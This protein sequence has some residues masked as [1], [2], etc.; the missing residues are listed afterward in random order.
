MALDNIPFDGSNSTGS[1]YHGVILRQGLT[2]LE[3][4]FNS[5]NNV[6]NSMNHM[7]DGDGSDIAHFDEMV[8][9][10]GF[11]DTTTAK[12]AWDELNSVLAKLNTDASVTTVNSSL[13]Q[14]FSKMR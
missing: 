9:R 12:A 10:Y 1:R 6:L 5:L 4:G 2:Q 7:V 3:S 13:L 14:I 8:V 11:P